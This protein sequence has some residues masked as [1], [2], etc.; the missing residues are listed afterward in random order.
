[1]LVPHQV[2]A[3]LAGAAVVRAQAA[4]ANGTT[5]A[6]TVQTAAEVSQTASSNT[7]AHL[8]S[9]TATPTRTTATQI[10]SNASETEAA[11]LGW[12]ELRAP[13]VPISQQYTVAVSRG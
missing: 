10:A 6:T 12:G 2:L 8:A 5:L 1:M 11:D 7:S 4:A 13:S 9:Q 3:F